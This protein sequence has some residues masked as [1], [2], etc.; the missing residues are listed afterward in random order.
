MIL[1]LLLLLLLVLNTFATQLTQQAPT[2]SFFDQVVSG[3]DERPGEREGVKVELAGWESD[4][5]GRQEEQ[6]QRCGVEELFVGACRV[7]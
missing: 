7:R 6:S 3:R 4:E 1:P 2:G 5:N